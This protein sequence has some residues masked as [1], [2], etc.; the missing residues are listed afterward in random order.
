LVFDIDNAGVPVA[1][2]PEDIIPTLD[3]SGLAYAYYSTYS[4]SRDNP[5][6]R[7]VIP[8]SE[9]ISPEDYRNALT[10]AAAWL[11]ISEAI[12]TSRTDISGVFFEPASPSIESAFSG[13]QVAGAFLEPALIQGASHEPLNGNSA[14]LTAQQEQWL[15]SPAVFLSAGEIASMLNSLPVT[16]FEYNE[17]LHIGMAIHYETSGSEAGLDLYDEWSI[18]DERYAGREDI[19]HRWASF[20]DTKKP[21]T[22]AY[23]KKLA[24]AVGWKP[25]QKLTNLSLVPFSSLYAYNQVPEPFDW[26]ISGLVEDSYVGMLTGAPG[27][28]K[29]FLLLELACALTQGQPFLRLKTKQSQVVFINAE[30]DSRMLHRRLQARVSLFNTNA[31]DVYERLHYL[32]TGDLDFLLQFTTRDGK[33]KDKHVTRLISQLRMVKAKRPTEPLMVIIDPLAAFNGGEENSNTDMSVFVNFMRLVCKQAGCSLIICHHDRKGV[34]NN[35]DI[36]DETGRGASAFFGGVRWGMRIRNV[37]IDELAEYGVLES[38]Q[39]LVNRSYGCVEFTKAN[40]SARLENVVFQRGIG[41]VIVPLTKLKEVELLAAQE[42]ET[43]RLLDILVEWLEANEH[44][45]LSLRTL[46]RSG[47]QAQRLFGRAVGRDM[48]GDVIALGLELKLLAEGTNPIK[49]A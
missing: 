18:A 25:Q 42:E 36:G 12:D 41:G 2:V 20:G 27:V 48:I 45:N 7:L 31:I 24:Q 14:A 9:P 4:S 16:N 39:S 28:G 3:T 6:W 32:Y 34:M 21:V 33:L 30:D 19:E 22:G 17:W 26:I 40:Y 15:N 44:K 37:T 43:K 47:R 1:I 29:S 46:Q 5:R 49:L 13:G 35:S 8:L 38:D 23:I 11:G 10:H